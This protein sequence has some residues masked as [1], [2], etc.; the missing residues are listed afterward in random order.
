MLSSTPNFIEKLVNRNYNLHMKHKTL[1]PI[2]FLSVF[3]I[4]FATP[5]FAAKG[6]GKP[7]PPSPVTVPNSICIDAGHGGSDVGA[8][9][10]DLKESEINLQV[11]KLLR[12]KL[13][14]VE[15]NVY[16][17]FM[18]RESDVYLTNA[19]RYNKCNSEGAEILISIHHNGASDPSIDYSKALYMKSE[20]VA[21]AQTVVDTVSEALGIENKGITRFASGVL[22]KSAMPATISEGFFLTSSDEYSKI[23]NDNR[24]DQEADALFDAIT[25][26]LN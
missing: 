25:A 26:Y 10:G 11:A 19:D 21:L 1:L 3:T 8:V 18:T 2:V 16:T 20:D 4:L 13:L 23:Q 5:V 17:V 14:D 9:N 24:L 22:L 7:V 12:D 6:K 15:G